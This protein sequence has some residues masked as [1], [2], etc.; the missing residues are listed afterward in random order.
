MIKSARRLL[1]HI[2]DHL[3]DRAAFEYGYDEGYDAGREASLEDQNDSH[4]SEARYLS[5]LNDKL[6]GEVTYLISEVNGK[7]RA[8][9]QDGAAVIEEPV[10]DLNARQH[11]S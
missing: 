1:K 9:R 11:A 5:A 4:Q 8:E 2:S 7:K 6:R 3:I 10:G